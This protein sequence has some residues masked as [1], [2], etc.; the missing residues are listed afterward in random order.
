[1]S[2][3]RLLD[4][5]CGAGGA[6]MGYHRAGFEVVGVDIKPQPHY[7]FEFHQADAL[8]YPLEGGDVIHA[9]PPCQRYTSLKAM[10][11]R[12]EHPDL[13]APT[14]ALLIE[15]GLPWVIEN[16]PGA[17]LINPITLCGSMFRLGCDGAE[18]RRHRIFETSFP[19]LIDLQ[20]QHGW[21]GKDS[22]VIGVYGHAGGYSNAQRYCVIGVCGGHGRDRRRRKNG[23]HFPT[24]QRKEAMGIDWMTG[25]ELSQAIPPA[26]TEFIGKQ[27]MR[28]LK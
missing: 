2:K 5:F 14:R 1:M 7:P 4:L 27:L 19:V 24:A 20:C 17:P 25:Q 22:A 15:S 11:N 9:S 12:M 26:Y 23:Q 10:W 18:L 16:V 21:S 6:A 8:T 13:V 28:I 3:P